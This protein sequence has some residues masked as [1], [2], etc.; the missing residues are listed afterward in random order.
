M[1]VTDRRSAQTAQLKN[2]LD[3][4]K[5]KRHPSHSHNGGQVHGRQRQ[6][7]R[8][9]FNAKTALMNFSGQADRTHDSNRNE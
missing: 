7:T 9:E 2:L 4:L 6:H 8:N 3:L 1:N 5:K